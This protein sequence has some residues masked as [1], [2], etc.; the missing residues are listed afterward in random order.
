MACLAKSNKHIKGYLLIALPADE[1]VLCANQAAAFPLAG[2]RFPPKRR[3]LI[4]ELL[5]ILFCAI[6]LR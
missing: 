6:Y 1:G 5:E 2:N 4:A 3:S